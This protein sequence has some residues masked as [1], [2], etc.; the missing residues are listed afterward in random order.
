MLRDYTSGL[1]VGHFYDRPM[2]ARV[3]GLG[4]HQAISRGVFTPTGTNLIFLFVTHEKQACLTQYNDFLDGDLLFWEGE[5][6][7][8]SD[9]RIIRASARGHEI[10]LFY[11]ERHHRL[12]KYHGRVVMAQSILHENRPSEFVFK[13]AAL[14]YDVAQAD[15]RLAH[16]TALEYQAVSAQGLNS[17]DREVITTTRGIAQ[18]IFRGNLLKMWHGACAVTGVQERR[19]LRAGHIKPWAESTSEE[20]V[21]R[22]NGLILVPDLDALF[23]KGLITFRENGRLITSPAFAPADQT[24]LR[25]CDDFK[26][27]EVPEPMQPYLDY[28]RRNRFIA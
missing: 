3:W 12:F 23:D 20:K 5:E 16:E 2:L 10:H 28:H 13:V 27:R 9:E 11:R 22:H 7:H 19:I 24:K 14:T 6:G 21:D 18:H 26:L 25:L 8:G 4:G 1:H 15:P 17:I